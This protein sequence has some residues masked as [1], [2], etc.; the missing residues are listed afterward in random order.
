MHGRRPRKIHKIRAELAT[1]G[2]KVSNFRWPEA[3]ESLQ[4]SG[5]AILLSWEMINGRR[6]KTSRKA[7][8]ERVPPL[9]NSNNPH[10]KWAA[11][12]STFGALV[13]RSKETLRLPLNDSRQETSKHDDS[14]KQ[15]GKQCSRPARNTRIFDLILAPSAAPYVGP[16]LCR[17]FA[18]KFVQKMISH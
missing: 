8:R 17:V 10:A 15:L 1:R 16:L 13:S 7:M 18:A 11:K 6:A 4:I 5:R 12:P 14:R 3:T 9:R 2:P